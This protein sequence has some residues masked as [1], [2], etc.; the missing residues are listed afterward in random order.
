P[1]KA[2]AT[3]SCCSTLLSLLFKTFKTNARDMACPCLTCIFVVSVF[4]NSLS[5]DNLFRVHF[6]LQTTGWFVLLEIIFFACAPF[7]PIIWWLYVY[8]LVD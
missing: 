6:L 5:D 8:N 4:V 2:V 1:N 3:A 7:G